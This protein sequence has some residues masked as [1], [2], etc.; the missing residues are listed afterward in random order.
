MA[1]SL[2]LAGLEVTGR[3]GELVEVGEE[4]GHVLAGRSPLYIFRW[5]RR[6]RWLD[7]RGRF[8]EIV[9]GFGVQAIERGLVLALGNVIIALL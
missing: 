2:R 3:H 6:W 4:A 9:H 7:I 1:I 5:R 8:G